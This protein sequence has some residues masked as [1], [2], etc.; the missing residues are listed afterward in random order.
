MILY[1]FFNKVIVKKLCKG[2]SIK[3]GRNV[4]GRICVIGRGG[5]NFSYYG[6]VLI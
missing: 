2:M 6:V 1:Y 5:F 4:H 3:S